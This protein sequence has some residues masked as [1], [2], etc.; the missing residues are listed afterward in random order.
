M[1]WFYNL[2]IAVKLIVGFVLVALLAGVVGVVGIINISKISA[3]DMNMYVLHTAT[4][5]DLGRVAQDYQRIRVAFRDLIIKTDSSTTEKTISQFKELDQSIDGSLADFEKGIR[6]QRVRETFENLK[7]TMGEFRQYRERIQNLVLSNQVDQAM[8]SMYGEGVTFANAVQMD[9]D[10]LMQLNVDLAKQS[11]ETNSATANAAILIMIIVIFAGMVIAI[12]LGIFI[13]RMISRPVRKLVNAADKLAMGDIDLNVVADTKDEVGDLTNAFHKM[14]DNIKEVNAEIN[15]LIGASNEGNLNERAAVQAF[16]GNWAALIKGLNGLLDIITAPMHE[17]NEVLSKMAVNDYTKEMTGQYKGILKE[18]AEQINM[19]RNRLLSVQDIAIRVSK[20]DTSRL[21]EFTK[22]GKRSDNDKLIPSFRDMM[23]VIQDLINET[24][25]LANASINGNLTSRGN[26]DKFE[27]GYKEIINGMNK[28]MDAVARP[29]QEASAVMQEMAKGNLTVTM[30]GDYKGDYAE[31]KESLN[32]TIQSFNDV[33]NEISNSAQ[34]VASGAKQVSDSAQTLSQG[35]T[36]QASSIEEQTASLEEISTQTRQNATN[37]NQASEMALAA[38]EDAVNGNERMKEMWNAMNDINESASNISKIIKVIDE[39]AFQT[40]IL[41]LNAAV[42]AAR[43]GQHGKGFAVVAEEVRNLAA[44]SAN[45]A[46]ETTVLIEGSIKKAEDGTKIASETA[47][48]LNKIVDVVTKVAHLVGEIAVA[49]NEQASGIAQV[50]QGIMQVSEVVQTNSATSEESASASEELSG[51]ADTL[52]N[53]VGKFKL[54]K[55][56]VSNNGL[57]GL[58]PEVLRLLENLN[59]MKTDGSEI[60][61][62][63]SK[64]AAKLKIALSDNEFGKY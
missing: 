6:D 43:A 11:S 39:I 25:L 3:L 44:R 52:K 5:D 32:F 36:E 58:N 13:S 51:Q 17:A 35:S 34:Q 22:I 46:K 62:T 1:K 37:A 45:A 15:K 12:V 21:D 61:K 8:S 2:K 57:D 41:A 63:K 33:L 20:G 4:L 31:I 19:V 60:R 40:N 30:N 23:Q 49:S 56:S 28:T 47:G 48:A 14:A 10:K 29:I 59:E 54:K 18:F 9:I 27:G 42:E 16:Q 53:L 26:T 24:S 50:N 38:K 55:G 7:K 64:T